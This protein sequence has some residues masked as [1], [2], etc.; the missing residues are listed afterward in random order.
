M[1]DYRPKKGRVRRYRHVVY[2]WRRRK[3]VRLEREQI[4]RGDS[5]ELPRGVD[6]SLLRDVIHLAY[7]HVES[8]DWRVHEENREDK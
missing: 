8:S 1:H 7:L 6:K 3:S 5:Q 4:E 2:Y